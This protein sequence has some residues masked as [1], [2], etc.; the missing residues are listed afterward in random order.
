MQNKCGSSGQGFVPVKENWDFNMNGNCGCQ[1][2]RGYENRNARR[3]RGS[4]GCKQ[5]DRCDDDRTVEC[6]DPNTYIREQETCGG[7]R[8]GCTGTE[9]C[10]CES[11][12]RSRG[13]NRDGCGKGCD[14]CNSK[15]YD[16]NRSG[17]CD[18]DD[19]CAYS[20]NYD[21]CG[22]ACDNG[23]TYARSGKNRGVGMVNGVMHEIDEIFQSESALRAGTLFPELH[24]PLNGYC[25]YDS[26]CG[27]CAQAAA[28]AVWELRLYLNTHP[29]DEEAL[30]LFRKL[31][32]EIK[33]E[34]YATAFLTD[35]CCT[36]GW[37]WVKNPW[38]WEYACQCG[39]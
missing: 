35:E 3:S 7:N 10:Q 12:V 31:C 30:Q 17:S 16:R 32:K 33:E 11:C 14:D 38:P 20:R 23:S 24:K 8:S 26:N 37:N 25:P 13:R 19:D 9:D 4:N 1:A 27:T 5:C 39:D 2:N 36:N 18:K 15:A 22:K 34:N 21:N 6:C 28:F 29:H